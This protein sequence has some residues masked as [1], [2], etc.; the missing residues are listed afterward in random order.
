MRAPERRVSAKPEAKTEARCSS[1][2]AGG[3]TII[4]EGLVTLTHERERVGRLPKILRIRA[5]LD[6]TEAAK[7]LTRHKPAPSVGAVHVP[8]GRRESAGGFCMR[9]AELVRHASCGAAVGT[10]AGMGLA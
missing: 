6:T 8:H 5:L 9:S 2:V 1:D 3:H 10:A 4:S 7:R